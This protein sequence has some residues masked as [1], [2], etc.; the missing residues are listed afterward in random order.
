MFTGNGYQL[1]DKASS[2]KRIWNVEDIL[3]IATGVLCWGDD[4][5]DEEEAEGEAAETEEEEGEEPETNE[6]DNLLTLAG[7]HILNMK[8]GAFSQSVDRCQASGAGK[9]GSKI[10][11]GIGAEGSRMPGV[12]ARDSLGRRDL[13]S[14]RTSFDS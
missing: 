6:E 14:N 10:H 4:D 1:Q 8:S 3:I 12:G 9:E 13:G 2:A 7:R 5:D 11:V